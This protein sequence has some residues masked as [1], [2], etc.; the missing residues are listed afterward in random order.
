MPPARGARCSSLRSALG[1]RQ[2]Q[3]LTY[4]LQLATH[5]SGFRVSD[6]E[7]FTPFVCLIDPQGKTS[8]DVLVGKHGDQV[9]A[10]LGNLFAMIPETMGTAAV[11]T[12]GRVGEGDKAQQVIDVFLSSA[13]RRTALHLQ[14][15]DVPDHPPTAAS[16][17]RV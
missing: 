10:Y 9:Q 17:R 16:L 7:A 2:T 1:A 6:A 14:W 12:S 3:L 13:N 8:S 11:M 5:S 4:C 15:L